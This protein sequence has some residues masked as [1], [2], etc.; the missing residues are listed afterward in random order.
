MSSRLAEEP[1]ADVLPRL[2]RERG[3]SQRALASKIGVNQSHLS[4]VL[5]RRDR[6]TP[7]VELM[8]KVALAL[9]LDED[10]FVEYRVALIMERLERDPSF[11]ERTY[12]GLKT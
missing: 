12:R 3:M 9:G 11:R 4:R 8:R 10:F 6:K 2:L 7:S 5:G 1:F